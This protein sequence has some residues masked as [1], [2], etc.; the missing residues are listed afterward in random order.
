MCVHLHACKNMH[1]YISTPQTHTHTCA[2]TKKTKKFF[3]STWETKWWPL[4]ST[5]TPMH[6]W[7]Y[8]Y[9]WLCTYILEY[10][11]IP[12]THT[13]K[14]AH[15]ATNMCTPMSTH[16]YMGFHTMWTHI[17]IH[18]HTT[19]M[20]AHIHTWT[21]TCTWTCTHELAHTWTCTHTYAHRVGNKS[22]AVLIQF[23]A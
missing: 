6:T 14:H 16:M 2:H 9:I 5:Y 17:Y 3:D 15:K 19:H 13:H 8:A 22:G 1:R 18:E 11:H 4:A 7:T 12:W 20:N 23:S 21:C 10:S